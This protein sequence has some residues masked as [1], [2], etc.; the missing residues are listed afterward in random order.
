MASKGKRKPSL[1]DLTLENPSGPDLVASL[2]EV[3]RSGSSD[4]ACALVLSSFLDRALV[5]LLS[6]KMTEVTEDD[7][8][9]MFMDRARS[10]VPSL[11][12]YD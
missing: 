11:Q 2:A 6:T 3:L 9:P 12:R 10:L 5:S 8:K 7:R 1:H 4:R